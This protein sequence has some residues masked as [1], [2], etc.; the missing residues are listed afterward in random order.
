MEIIF[1]FLFIIIL[2]KVLYKWYFLLK[3]FYVYQYNNK[4]DI[5]PFIYDMDTI[6]TILEILFLVKNIKNAK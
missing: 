2:F 3:I 6:R 5:M 1:L 4:Y